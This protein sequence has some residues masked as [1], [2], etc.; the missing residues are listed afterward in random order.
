MFQTF[1]NRTIVFRDIVKRSIFHI[2]V[3]PSSG[4]V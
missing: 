3:V 2:G 1:E 4:P